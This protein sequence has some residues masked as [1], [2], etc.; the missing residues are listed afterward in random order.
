MLGYLAA[1]LAAYCS[2]AARYQNS[3]PRNIINY[4]VNIKAYGLSSQ[5]VFYLNLAYFF[6]NTLFAAVHHLINGGHYFKLA[7]GFLA[8]VEY[9]SLF[10]IVA[11]GN[12]KKNCINLKFFGSLYNAVPVAIDLNA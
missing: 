12:S 10:L 6:G 9:F 8:D 2:A 3:A 1:K 11:A 7:A 4:A 5:K